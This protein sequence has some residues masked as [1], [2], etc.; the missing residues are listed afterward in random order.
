MREWGTI[1]TAVPPLSPF[2]AAAYGTAPAHRAVWS[3]VA[4]TFTVED[5]TSVQLPQKIPHDEAEE[6]CPKPRAENL[7]SGKAVERG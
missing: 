7:Q 2:K 3:A 6:T 5:P 1:T 4:D